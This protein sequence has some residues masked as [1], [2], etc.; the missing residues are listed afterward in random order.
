MEEDNNIFKITFQRCNGFV[1]CKDWSGELLQITC[2]YAGLSTL[3]R[4]PEEIG[5][6]NIYFQWPARTK[7]QRMYQRFLKEG[8][9]DHSILRC[10]DLQDS[11]FEVLSSTIELYKVNLEFAESVKDKPTRDDSGLIIYSNT[12]NFAIKWL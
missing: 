4:Y 11:N 9:G 1:T 10:P 6:E 3:G 7:H 8:N 2:F 12:I 5:Q